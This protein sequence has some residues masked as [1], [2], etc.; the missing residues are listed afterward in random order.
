MHCSTALGGELAVPSE[1]RH[2]VREGNSNEPKLR[3]WVA[4]DVDGVI[5][6]SYLP[7]MQYGNGDDANGDGDNNVENGVGDGEAESVAESGVERPTKFAKIG[8][9]LN[10]RMGDARAWAG[11]DDEQ[12]RHEERMAKRKAY[13]N[14]L[15][16]GL[17][18]V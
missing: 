5:T 7:G 10:S 18:D 15:T 1:Q 17:Y 2:C 16:G 13:L 3:V 12:K 14:N 4:A 9:A 11:I 8:D 6:D